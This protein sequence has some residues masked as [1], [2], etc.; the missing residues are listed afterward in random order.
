T[1]DLT[2]DE[3]YSSRKKLTSIMTEQGIKCILV[4]LRDNKIHPEKLEILD[5]HKSHADVFPSGTKM[6]VVYS[7]ETWS[8]LDL[9]LAEHLST[10]P[11]MLMNYF[12][13]IE[14]AIKWL[15]K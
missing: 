9:E 3:A 10:K 2:I 13:E 15:T 12:L 4:D 5:F 7:P 11:G 6:A 1:E 8:L 14:E